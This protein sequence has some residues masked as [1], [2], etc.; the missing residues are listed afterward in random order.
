MKHEEIARLAK[1]QA[2]RARNFLKRGDRAVIIDMHAGDGHGVTGRQGDLFSGFE[3]TATA[4]LAI[5]IA[6]VLR[7]HGIVVDVYLCESA[8]DRRHSLQV[9]AGRATILRDHRKLPPL[10]IYSWGLVL[11]DPNGPSK[12]GVDIMQRL[13]GEVPRID[14]IIVVNE[15]ACGRIAGVRGVSSDN[16]APP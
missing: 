8:K 1:M 4:R 14:F 5:E 9:F 10:G 11:N 3:S 13:A 2:A 6:A 16:K 7:D 12:H 15:G